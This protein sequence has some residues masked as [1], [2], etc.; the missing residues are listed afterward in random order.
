MFHKKWFDDKSFRTDG[1]FKVSFEK[2]D[3]TFGFDYT[4][5]KDGGDKNYSDDYRPHFQNSNYVNSK[6]LGI[7]LMD[8]SHI[9][10][11]LTIKPGLRYSYYEGKAGP[12]GKEEF[13]RLFL[14]G[15]FISM[16]RVF[17]NQNLQNTGR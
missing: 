11:N 15:L 1:T 5:F 2:H 14:K 17:L 8:D 6:I 4:R 16:K 7:Y 10:E 9:M 3:I 12:A 13:Q